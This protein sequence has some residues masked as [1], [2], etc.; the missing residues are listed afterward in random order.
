MAKKGTR[1]RKTGMRR[2]HN[3]RRGVSGKIARKSPDVD[4]LRERI[5]ADPRVLVGKPVIRGTRIGVAFVMDLMAQG[6]S[7]DDILRSYPRLSR[8]DIRACLEYVKTL[9]DAEKVYP[10]ESR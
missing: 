3:V 5:V 2:E 8:E 9:L 6:W 10:L 4:G 1:Q 7:E